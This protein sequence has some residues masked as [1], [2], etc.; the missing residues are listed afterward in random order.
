MRTFELFKR[1]F[2]PFHR[3]YNFNLMKAYNTKACKIYAY[4]N[5]K[6]YMFLTTAKLIK[7]NI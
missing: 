3:P 1:I 4:H 2:K 5:L 6:A 7:R